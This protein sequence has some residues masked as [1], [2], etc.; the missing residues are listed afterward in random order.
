MTAHFSCGACGGDF[1]LSGV[2]SDCVCVCVCAQSI[3][4][5]VEPTVIFPSSVSYLYK[6]GVQ[7][8][9]PMYNAATYQGTYGRQPSHRDA[10][11]TSQ[12]NLKL[13]LHGKTQ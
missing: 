11:N 12:I 5:Y 7:A 8:D 9:R 10:T 6:R 3:R 2:K 13:H 1:V 4:N